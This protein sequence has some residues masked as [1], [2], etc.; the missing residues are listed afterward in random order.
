MLFCFCLVP[1]FSRFPN[2][3]PQFLVL[4]SSI[5]RTGPHL[6]SSP[7]HLPSANQPLRISPLSWHLHQMSV[8]PASLL[9]RRSHPI[10]DA[11]AS[12]RITVLDGG[13]GHLLRRMGVKVEGEVG[14]V[15]RFL[16]VALANIQKPELVVQAHEA[17]INAGKRLF[18]SERADRADTCKALQN[19]YL[20]LQLSCICA[21][22]RGRRHHY[23]Q[24]RLHSFMF[25]SCQQRGH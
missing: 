15:Q 9:R 23:Q 19:N 3:P 18:R 17:Y 12:R 14:T 6:R 11:P 4:Q 25:V 20:F 8:M 5:I 2:F 1:A 21:A 22:F 13:M 16:G 24:L 7:L 10:D